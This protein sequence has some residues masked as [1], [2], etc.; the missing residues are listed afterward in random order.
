MSGSERFGGACTCIE[1]PKT[2]RVVATAARNSSSLGSGAAPIAVPGFARKFCT[3]ISWMCRWR[4]CTSR[5]AKRDS[6]RSRDV[7][8]IPTRIPDVNGIARRPASSIV[9]IR[10]AGTLSGEPK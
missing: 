9:R 5:S 4:R 7:S 1:A 6:A 10:T 3:M 8:P 2:T